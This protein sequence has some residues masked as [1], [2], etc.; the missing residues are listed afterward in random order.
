MK[1]LRAGHTLRISSFLY[2]RNLRHYLDTE[3]F[4]YAQRSL[5]KNRPRTQ[6]DTNQTPHKKPSTWTTKVK[7]PTNS[8][9]ETSYTCKWHPHPPIICLSS[10]TEPRISSAADTFTHN[11]SRK[12][13]PFI[14]LV[15]YG[16]IQFVLLNYS[17]ISFQN[18]SGP[19]PRTGVETFRSLALILTWQSLNPP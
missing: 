9:P 13:P 16:R 1:D 2:R 18:T 12:K 4:L 5:T 17:I 6:P 15:K 8:K 3:S 11:V 7:L 10:V 19:C 14:L